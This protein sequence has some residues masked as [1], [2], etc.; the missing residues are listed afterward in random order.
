MAIK[1]KKFTNEVRIQ[2]SAIKDLASKKAFLI[3]FLKETTNVQ[4]AKIRENISK[5]RTVMDLEIIMFGM[6]L[7]SEGQGVIR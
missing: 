7:K 3:D 4:Y 1:H 6:Q 2:V 5:A